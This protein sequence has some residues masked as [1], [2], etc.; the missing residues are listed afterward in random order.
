MESA[1]TTSTSHLTTTHASSSA[2]R[3]AALKF[4]PWDLSKM[5]IESVSKEESARKQWESMYGWMADIDAKV[6]LLNNR[7]HFQF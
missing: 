6:C 1:Y 3:S 4:S 2:K 7:N 5:W